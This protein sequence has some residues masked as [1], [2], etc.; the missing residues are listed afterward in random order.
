M[1][2]RNRQVSQY[3]LSHVSHVTSTYFM[4]TIIYLYRLGA[5]V[6]SKMHYRIAGNFGDL[7]NILIIVKFKTRQSKLNA[8][9]PT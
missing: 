4:V 6:P 3:L 2:F 1:V 9:T 8:C 7:A 5:L